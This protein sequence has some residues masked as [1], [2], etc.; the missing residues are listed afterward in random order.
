VAR[1][2]RMSLVVDACLR[3]RGSDERFDH[4]DVR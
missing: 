3:D 4:R 1:L 2:H